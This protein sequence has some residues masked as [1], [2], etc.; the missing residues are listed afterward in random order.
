MSSDQVVRDLMN[1]LDEYQ[2]ATFV[3]D[4]YSELI[5]PEEEEL[6]D[7]DDEQSI[8]HHCWL[9]S[10]ERLVGEDPNNLTN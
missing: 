7:D 6:D 8:T 2:V 10:S 9:Q 3:D 1:W 5:D 4:N